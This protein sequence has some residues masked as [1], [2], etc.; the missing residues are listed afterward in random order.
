MECYG[1]VSGDGT[2]WELKSGIYTYFACSYLNRANF[3][4]SRFGFIK[5]MQ[6]SPRKRRPKKAPLI[7]PYSGFLISIY[8]LCL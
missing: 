5:R 2:V 4:S 7:W 8:G 3:F 1:G 6:S